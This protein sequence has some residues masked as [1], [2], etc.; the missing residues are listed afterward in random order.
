VTA[1]NT[2]YCQLTSNAVRATFLQAYKDSVRKFYADTLANASFRPYKTF[3]TPVSA[4]STRGPLNNYDDIIFDINYPKGVRSNTAIAY[5]DPTTKKAYYVKGDYLN[6]TSA[7]I[8]R[9]DSTMLMANPR[10]GVYTTSN[11]GGMS[12]QDG[13][14]KPAEIALIKAWY[15]ADP[16]I[17]DM[18]KY[19]TSG[20]GIFKYKVSGK[21]I[22]K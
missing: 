8:Y 6:G 12:N 1:V 13:G 9:L 20:T 3:S 15:F 4:V 17:P 7:I 11:T 5:T 21:V 19:G 10:T 16:N 22:T 14:I 18:W 2:V